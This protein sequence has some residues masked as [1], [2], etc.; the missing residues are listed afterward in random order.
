MRS[1]F[2]IV[3]LFAMLSPYVD[4]FVGLVS[5]SASHF[6]RSTLV[7]SNVGSDLL[8]L[9]PVAVRLT[10]IN[11]TSPFFGHLVLDLSP[12][13]VAASVRQPNGSVIEVKQL[14]AANVVTPIVPGMMRPGQRHTRLETLAFDLDTLFPATGAYQ[15]SF[16]VTSPGRETAVASDSLLVRVRSPKGPDLAAYDHIRLS[17]IRGSFFALADTGQL[18]QV[19][20]LFPQSRYAGR[21][22]ITL[23]QRA[24]ALQDSARAI[25]LLKA[26]STPGSPL[27]YEAAERLSDPDLRARRR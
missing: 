19:V 8:P 22:L 15:V 7:A 12:G 25:E 20:T 6:S 26:A 11:G 3:A 1:V 24:R 21:A 17:P 10:A 2:F 14:S 13:R 27:S 5:R 9:E 4:S 16:R 18:Q 23:A